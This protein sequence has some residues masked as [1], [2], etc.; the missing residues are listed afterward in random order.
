M[1]T[2]AD[3]PDQVPI[4]VDDSDRDASAPLLGSPGD[5]LQKPGESLLPNLYIGT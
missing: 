2:A 3:T 4:G 5:V 1:A